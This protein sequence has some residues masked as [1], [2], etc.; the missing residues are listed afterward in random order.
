VIAFAGPVAEYRVNEG[1]INIDAN[2]ERILWALKELIPSKTEII[3]KALNHGELWG[4]FWA[5]VYT[6][7][8]CIDWSK[9][10][11]DL[12][13]FPELANIDTSIFETVWPFAQQA[14]AVIDFHWPTVE[15]MASRLIELK[16][17]AGEEIV[18]LV[19]PGNCPTSHTDLIWWSSSR[20]HLSL[21][22]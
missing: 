20:K 6:L 21:F 19:G 4:E 8:T 10:S 2:V 22:Q 1:L 15:R 14:H 16:S 3:V 5:L 11:A 12:S 17:I 13:E 7:A 9:A 18:K